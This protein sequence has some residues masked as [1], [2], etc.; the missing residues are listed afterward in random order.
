MVAVRL[1]LAG[2]DSILSQIKDRL[3]NMHLF[4]CMTNAFHGNFQSMTMILNLYFIWKKMY[5]T[6]KHHLYVIDALGKKQ[7]KTRVSCLKS[8]WKNC[9]HTLNF[10]L[11]FLYVWKCFDELFYIKQ[12]K[13][14]FF[15]PFFLYCLK[16]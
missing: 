4:E 1:V 2:S 13:L 14:V 16:A 15:S 11:I 12:E 6:T 10:L 5:N 7:M 3:S 9:I 8:C